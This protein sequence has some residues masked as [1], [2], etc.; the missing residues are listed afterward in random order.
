MSS[1]VAL[2]AQL[3]AFAKRILISAL[4]AVIVKVG[5]RPPEADRTI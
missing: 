3:N 5:A 1:H 4:R 2:R